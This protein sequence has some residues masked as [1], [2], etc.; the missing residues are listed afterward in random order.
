MT[1]N[2]CGFRAMLVF[3]A[4]CESANA[5]ALPPEWALDSVPELTLG[6]LATDTSFVFRAIVGA[7]RLPNGQVLVADRADPAFSL[8]AA[9]GRLVRSFGRSGQGPGELA[10]IFSMRRCGDS[11]V[12][13]ELGTWR[14]VVFGLDGTYLR[15]FRFR[16]P[17]GMSVG[18]G[19]RACNGAGFFVHVGDGT[20]PTDLLE[21]PETRTYRI[22]Q[23]VWVSAM[24]S[25]VPSAMA[26]ISGDDRVILRGLGERGLD[27]PRLFGVRAHAAI[28]AERVYVGTGERAVVY[29]YGLGGALA[30]SILLGLERRAV[31]EADLS[32]LRAQRLAA[33]ATQADSE[34][35]A[36]VFA[37]TPMPDVMPAYG[38]L[39]IDANDDLWVQ[40]YRTHPSVPAQWTVIAPSGQ[41]LGRVRT[42]PFFDVLEIGRDYVLGR[43]LAPAAL[44]PEVRL[45]RYCRCAQ[46]PSK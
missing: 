20:L 9:D 30:D 29:V 33:V 32:R 31:R 26:T 4:A 44:A 37:H 8:F 41:V 16:S 5:P 1:R 38:G 18:T 43:H 35:V 22:S 34:E 24:D 6:A 42:P 12:V 15:A 23:R 45:Y 21:S 3:A 17:R 14:S 10:S 28:G 7:T 27:M 2:T 39:A 25:V 13:D 40:D 46:A 19:L 11:V 36:F